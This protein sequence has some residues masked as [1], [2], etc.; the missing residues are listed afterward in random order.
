MDTTVDYSALYDEQ[1]DFLWG[2]GYRLTGSAADAED[3]V[4]DVFIRAMERPPADTSRPWR[5]WL[6]RV[7]TNLVRDGARRDRLGRKSYVGPWLPSP[8]ASDDPRIRLTETDASGRY[9]M[10][11]SVSMAFLLALEVLSSQQR[12]VLLLR[13]VYDYSV[14]ETSEI[15]ELTPAN[16]KTTLH[17]ARQALEHYDAGR[18]PPT[19]ERRGVT[20]AVLEKLL[21]SL[22]RQDIDGIEAL[23]AEG[24]QAISDGNGRFYAAK[25]PVF[26]RHRVASL[27]AKISPAP[28]ESVAL[29]IRELNGLPALI[30]ERPEA[31]EGYA[32][33]F[34]L[35]LDVDDTGQIL[36]IY[37]VLNSDKL[38]G[39]RVGRGATR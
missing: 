25:K 3:L 36:A 32:Q 22:G 38:H 18:R 31:P 6:V 30:A 4:Q 20:R 7:V 35:L 37:N 12:A 8:V 1:R 10:R 16:V 34:V 17:R 9:E 2:Y 15:L 26:G 21:E 23:L 14:Q 24:V 19:E 5:P 29:E 27:Y 39:L 33:R 13:D 28:G 11:E